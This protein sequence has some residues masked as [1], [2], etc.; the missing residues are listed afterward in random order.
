M[1]FVYDFNL[2]VIIR[3]KAT[4]PTRRFYSRDRAGFTG[5]LVFIYSQGLVRIGGSPQ[6]C[7]LLQKQ[8]GVRFRPGLVS[9]SNEIFY[10][11]A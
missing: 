1:S 9:D 6:T 7:F 3:D 10:Y 8:D 11:S 4:E 2:E 5:C